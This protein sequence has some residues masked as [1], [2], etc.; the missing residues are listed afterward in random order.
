[1]NLQNHGLRAHLHLVMDCCLS[2]FA[3]CIMGEYFIVAFFQA[4]IRQMQYLYKNFLRNSVGL[5]SRESSN[6]P[7][8]A[9]SHKDSSA[10]CMDVVS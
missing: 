4:P 6:S 5:L 2:R 8:V 9:Q 3:I 7:G 1:M 10:G